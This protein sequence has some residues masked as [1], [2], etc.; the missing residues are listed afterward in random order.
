MRHPIDHPATNHSRRWW[1]LLAGVLTLFGA[2]GEPLAP[3]TNP[4]IFKAWRVQCET[5]EGANE[6]HCFLFQDLRLKK[7]NQ[8]LLHILVRHLQ[9]MGF[10][11]CILN[12]FYVRYWEICQMSK[13]VPVSGQ[14]E[15]GF[16]FHGQ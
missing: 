1:M 9:N 15:S 3:A 5:P 4:Q 7:S 10:I 14:K 11:A 13:D 8:Q 2:N 6:E 12:F 16:I